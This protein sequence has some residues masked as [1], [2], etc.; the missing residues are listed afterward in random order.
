M[1]LVLATSNPGKVREL[2]RLLAGSAEVVSPVEL[3]LT[4]DVD[5]DGDTYEANAVK[6][7]RAYAA[8]SGYLA[9]A[10]DSGIEVDALDGRPGLRSARYGGDGLDDE[11]RNILLLKELAGVP[12]GRRTARYRAAVALA[13]PDGRTEVFRGDFEGSIGYERRG[14]DGFGYD[15]LFV[16]GDGRT[17][18]ELSDSEKDA[19]SH[20]AQAVRAAA[21]FLRALTPDAS[22]RA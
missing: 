4:L 20:R 7:A 1:R 5:E 12:V 8:A 16:T 2:Q 9:L 21:A 14:R 6:K 15:P 22:I 19:V 3:G 18:A 11:G 10:D 17:A 13:W